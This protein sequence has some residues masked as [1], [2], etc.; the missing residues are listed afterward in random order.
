[1]QWYYAIEG[2]QQGPVEESDLQQLAATGTITNETLVWNEGMADW[3]PYAEVA[4]IAPAAEAPAQP[5]VPHVAEADVVL[6]P[7][8]EACCACNQGFPAD[9]MIN[10]EGQHVCAGCKES[11]FQR[12]R[13][14]A[15][16]P[17]GGGGTGQT[18]NAELMANARAAL[19]GQWGNA[20]GFSFLYQIVSQL[21]GQI[22]YLGVIIQL[23]IG[24]AFAVGN[25]IFYL[26]TWRQQEARIGMMFDGFKQFGTALWA[27]FLVG[28]KVFLYMLLLI[29]PGIIKSYSYVMVYYILADHPELTA[30]EALSRSERMMYG[31]RMK[32]FCLSWRFFGWS[33]LCML[34][35]FIGF[36]WLIPYMSTSMAA[37]YDDVRGLGEED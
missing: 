8:H 4:A 36:L 35:L 32:F 33:L 1:M 20:V 11:F 25:Q 27:G 5:L 15:P 21:P 28:L 26:A 13:E 37:F 10:Y 19:Q 6:Q 12:I 14:G 31:N 17:L 29:V 9:E 16:M 34:T 7:G 22:P 3:K 24:P 30:K 23:I 2:E 18:P